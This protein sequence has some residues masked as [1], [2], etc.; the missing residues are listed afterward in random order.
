MAASQTITI[1][2]PISIQT[3]AAPGTLTTT[4]TVTL[5]ATLSVQTVSSREKTCN[6]AW[7]DAIAVTDP[8]P[9]GTILIG[10]GFVSNCLNPMVHY[11]NAP[12]GQTWQ[13]GALNA[14]LLGTPAGEFFDQAG[15]P[16][17]YHAVG[18][19]VGLAIAQQ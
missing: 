1:P 9:A 12:S 18:Y 4:G 8:C 16:R 19:C 15:N 6:L 17:S 13:F 7:P 11:V 3:T 5:Q 10:G 2:V 14:P